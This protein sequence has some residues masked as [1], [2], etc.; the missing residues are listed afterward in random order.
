MERAYDLVI[1]GGMLVDGSGGKAFEADVAVKDGLIV[2]V[3]KVAGAGAEEIDARGKLV[4]PGFVDIHTHYDGQAT[5][6]RHMQPSSWHG[7]TT[8]VM[9]NCGVGFAPCKPADHDRLVRLM[10][11]VEDIPFPVLTEGLPWN[12]E[13]F[14]DYLDSLDGRS[15]DVD[16]GAQLPHAALR[17]FVMG[18]RGA[19]REDATPADIAAMAAIAKGAV[20]AG[21]LGFSTSRTL[22]HR[23]SDGQPTP[24]LTASEDELTGIAMGLAAAGKGAL[25]FVSDFGDPEAEFAMLRRIVETSGR[26]LS[27]S[28]VQSPIQPAQWRLLLDRLE[29]ASAAGLPMRAQVCGRPVGV[30]FGLELTLNPFTHYPSYKAI[31]GQPLAERAAKL[32]DPTFRAQLLSEGSQASAAFAANM[33]QNWK[34][35][36]LM[37]ETPDYEQ[38]PD[39]TVL[40]LADAR[41]VRP[42]ELALEHMLTNGGRGML[43]LPFLNYAGGSLDPSFEMLSHPDTVPGLSDGGA[44]VGMICD[45]SFPTSN[46]TLWTRDRTR[47]PKLP[48]ETMVRMQSHDTAAA[49]GLHDR[50]LVAPGY[51]ADLNVIDYER[52]S[53]ESPRVAYDL[54]AGGR[55]LIQRAEGYVATIVAG[56][57]TYRDGE[58]TGAL[59][60]RLLRGAQA[61]PAA[62]A[63]E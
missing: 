41:G 10:E 24:T 28:L 62:I 47:G 45:G 37:G 23:T 13:S 12:W 16:I 53:L 25:Q 46:L 48:L 19:N 33:T 11:G 35:M 26:P 61:A 57:V 29:E 60:G 8:V 36:F 38:T 27:F 44:H 14:P 52:L 3:G 51:R 34:V 22:N 40:A 6:D 42:E 4:T 56:E 43:Y 39:R 9:G 7:V 58:P 49:L 15:F 63:A 55:R 17:V 21:A 18:E 30:L 31:A 32:A 2:Q 59:P 20:E 50:G 54:P 5:W 1:R